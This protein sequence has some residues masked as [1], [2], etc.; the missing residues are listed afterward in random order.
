MAD[1]PRDRFFATEHL[2]EEIEGRAARGGRIIA[3]TQVL[4][5]VLD[6]AST[7]I[8]VRVLAPD[9]WGLVGMVSAVIGFV[10]LFKDLGLTTATIQRPTITHREVTAL[11]WINVAFS[12]VLGVLVIALA[13]ALAW[14]YEEPQLLAITVALSSVF[15]V[16][17]FGAQHHAILRRQMQFG[18]VSLIDAVSLSVGM[19][20][21][22]VAA[23]L[24]AGLWALVLKRVVT[25]SL[26]TLFVWIACKWRP[27]APKR[28]KGLKELVAFGANVTGF[29]LINY[30]A[31]NLDDVLIGR[32]DGA[33]AAERAETLGN[34]QKAYELLMLPLQQLNK[35]VSAVA[36]PALSRLSEQPE[37]YRA[38]Y[39]RIMRLV[40]MVTMPLTAFLVMTAGPLVEVVFG[41]QWMEAVPIFEVLGLAAFTQP[42]G[43]SAGWLFIS[44]DRTAE[45]LRWGV[46][47]AS[48]AVLS[49]VVG[50]PWGAYGIAASYALSG[51]FVR[52][53]IL[54]WWL[55][56]RGPVTTGDFYVVSAPYLVSGLCA[57]GALYGLR[58]TGIDHPIPMLVLSAVV[59]LLAA[60][61]PLLVS[62]QGRSSLADA[63]Q[64]V[65][66]RLGKSDDKAL[67]ALVAEEIDDQEEDD[68]P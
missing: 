41:S 51:I 20:V 47:G 2:D 9:D 35:P 26:T 22:V 14:F 56:R 29:S 12:V 66:T 40:L 39:L 23:F 38:V 49:F 48:L 28:E 55:G 25:A 13:P 6:V 44:Q 53:P 36:V 33:T 1:D 64:V 10:A 58:F 30:F 3:I 34:Y 31:R 16:S 59:A 5:S 67:P 7:L 27:S 62:E 8:L 68:G 4:R 37:R 15:F 65:S 46:V 32:F 24:G 43:N 11:M 50:L 19:I 45:M 21:A 18:L 61:L 42:L 57:A 60:I 17:G 52:T 54:L 63:R